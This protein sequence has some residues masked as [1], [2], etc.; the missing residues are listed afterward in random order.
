MAAHDDAG[1]FEFISIIFKKKWKKCGQ[2]GMLNT[3]CNEHY[4]CEFVTI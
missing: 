2:V 3:Y 4:G 1:H